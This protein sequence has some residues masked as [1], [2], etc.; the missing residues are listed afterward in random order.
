MPAMLTKPKQ[1][2]KAKQVQPVAAPVLA[3]M[4]GETQ[5][6]FFDRGMRALKGT[7]PSVNRRTIEVIR[8]WKQSPNDQDLREKAMLQFSP[9]KYQIYGPRCVFLEHTIPA[10]ADGSRDAINYNRSALEHLIK[11]ANFRI[12]NSDMFSAISDGHTPTKEELDSGRSQPDVLGYAGP[13][14]LG[15]LGDVEPKYAIYADE[16]VH[17]DDVPRFDKLQRRSPEVWCNEPIQR[18]TLDPIAALGAETPRLDSGMN[19]YSRAGDGVTV[20]RYSAMAALPGPSNTYV[21]GGSGKSRKTNYGAQEMA[22]NPGQMPGQDPNQ[23]PSQGGS[24][25]ADIANAVGQAIQS[26]LPSIVQAVLQQMGGDEGTDGDQMPADDSMGMG[27]Q[28]ETGATDEGDG[29]PRG[30]EQPDPTSVQPDPSEGQQSGSV[31]QQKTDPDE[32]RYSAMGPQCHAAYQAGKKKGSTMTQTQQ[33]AREKGVTDVHSTIAKLQAEV[34]RLRKEI[35]QERRDAVRYSKLNALAKDY[36]FSADE[37]LETCMD[38]DDT[39]FERH[40]TKTVTKYARRDDVTGVDF[41]D[42]ADVETDE[43]ARY[44]RGSTPSKND[45]QKIERYSREAANNAARNGT[46]FDVEFDAIMKKNGL[47]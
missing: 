36:A 35:E 26:L 20:M 43:P 8:V 24:G 37:E 14:Y 40:V 22:F 41:F 7:I 25:N 9:A 42:D 39:Q 1:T 11:W 3:P 29:V 44:G 31:S 2:P 34:I 16:Y 21:P 33:Y 32:Q 17:L 46:K 4:Q 13:F 23:D 28:T 5:S 10:A 27:D 45:V 6:Q 12:R 47:A 30:M 19:P 15:L 18:R 38:M